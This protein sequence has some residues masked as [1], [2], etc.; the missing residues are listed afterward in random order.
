MSDPQTENA[1]QR[2]DIMTSTTDGFV[3][4]ERDLEMR[5]PGD[6]F[7]VRQSGLPQ[8]KVAD[9]TEDYRI[10]EVAREEAVKV[11]ETNNL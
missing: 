2:M 7:G 5:G 6:Y 10:L 3:L 1:K 8:F 9:I 11:Y 4:S